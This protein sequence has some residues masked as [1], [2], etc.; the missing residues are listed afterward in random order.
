M[1]ALLPLSFLLLASTAAH[2]YVP[3]LRTIPPMARKITPS[4]HNQKEIIIPINSQ[5][6]S[7]SGKDMELHYEIISKY[8]THAELSLTSPQWQRI[9]AC[10][11][12]DSDEKVIKIDD[13]VLTSTLENG[14]SC[15]LES[16]ILRRAASIRLRYLDEKGKLE[17]FP[18]TAP[19]AREEQKLDFE[20]ISP[21]IAHTTHIQEAPQQY[22]VELHPDSSMHLL[23][24]EISAPASASASLSLR[25]H[26][27]SRSLYGKLHMQDAPPTLNAELKILY[28]DQ[29]LESVTLPIQADKGILELRGFT[30]SYERMRDDLIALFVPEGIVIKS[31]VIK[32]AEGKALARH[33]Q[34]QLNI[35]P[36]TGVIDQTQSMKVFTLHKDNPHSI[37]IQ[38]F[39][40]PYKSTTLSLNESLEPQQQELFIGNG[41]LLSAS[42]VESSTIIPILDSPRIN[43]IPSL[44]SY[45]EIYD[46]EKL[47]EIFD[48]AIPSLQHAKSTEEGYFSGHLANF[49]L[50]YE[51]RTLFVQ[52]LNEP[53]QPRIISVSELVKDEE[54]NQ[55]LSHRGVDI[56][57]TELYNQLKTELQKIRK[58]EMGENY[59]LTYV[60]TDELNTVLPSLVDRL[61]IQL[62]R[63]A[64]L[65]SK[66]EDDD[67]DAEL[68]DIVEKINDI[69]ELI[70]KHLPLSS[71]PMYCGSEELEK[72]IANATESTSF[73]DILLAIV[74][75]LRASQT[76]QFIPASR[77]SQF[78]LQADALPPLAMTVR[79]PH[80]LLRQ[81]EEQPLQ[82]GSMPELQKLSPVRRK[83]LLQL[84]LHQ[85][86]DPLSSSALRELE[87]NYA[88]QEA[89]EEELRC[90][91]DI[92]HIDTSYTMSSDLDYAEAIFVPDVLTYFVFSV[93][94]R[95]RDKQLLALSS[96]YPAELVLPLLY[97]QE[98][99]RS[100]LLQYK[101]Y[102]AVEKAIPSPSSASRF[103]PEQREWLIEQ[104]R[105]IIEKI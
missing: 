47:R 12:L 20:I 13:I 56:V 58:I 11:L 35:D 93:Y 45:T 39:P 57:A 75:D 27:E 54:N 51:N 53:T 9:V 55:Y 32:D 3:E 43:A 21:I 72:L 91:R 38:Y 10:H 28:S 42:L 36:E 34:V 60:N 102:S 37:E 30:L 29:G 64:Q 87:F 18:L 4:N 99:L 79:H 84:A 71:L 69:E 1:K 52:L 62:T 25:R 49:I 17:V 90:L 104:L 74:A 22:W 61:C 105:A 68:D 50:R 101:L 2:A 92:L 31:E 63:L 96:K 97:P 14:S 65:E 44:S 67:F 100:V 83:F 26:D 77:A 15:Y 66:L 7:F 41:K 81:L 8:D 6:G 59:S 76:A 88:Y 19:I 86:E 94:E 78:G 40:G 73:G 5:K 16:A 82:L 48:T 95:N 98:L 33:G 80:W 24:A 46:S 70:A 85:L 103:T 23:D 89:V